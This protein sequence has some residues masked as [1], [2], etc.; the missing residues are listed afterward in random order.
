MSSTPHDLLGMVLREF[1][2]CV[3]SVTMFGSRVKGDARPS[4]D[5]DVIIIMEQL[6]P[7]PNV[8]EGL[9]ASAIANILLESGFRISPIVLTREEATDEVKSGSP[10]FASILSNYKILYDPTGFMAQLLDLTKRLCPNITYVERGRA[11][12]LAR[13]V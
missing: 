3:V 4:S 7:N 5:Y 6:D 1:G 12:N 11:W 8:R 10:L 9:A 13:T 2:R